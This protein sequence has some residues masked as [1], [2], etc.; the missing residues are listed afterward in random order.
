MS[1]AIIFKLAA[2]G[3]ITAI[4][5]MLLKQAGK[6]DVATIVSFVGLAVALVMMLNVIMELYKTIGDIFGI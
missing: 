6:E 4:V 1:V 5:A 2:V 3:I